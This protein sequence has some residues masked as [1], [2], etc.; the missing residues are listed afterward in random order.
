[1]K[2]IIVSVALV[3]IG[4]TTACKKEVIPTPPTNSSTDLKDF[5]SSKVNQL[6]QNFTV[7]AT[8]GATIIGSRGTKVTILPNGLKW[9]NGQTVSGNVNIELVEIFDRG[10]MVLANKPTMG[11]LPNGDLAPLV[12]GGEYYLRITQNGQELST[13]S[14]VFIE[15]PTFNLDAGMQLFDGIIDGND[16]LTWDLTTDTINFNQDSLGTT[17]AFFDDSW[18]WTNVDR[19][20]DDPRPKTTIKVK[21]PSG[22]DNSNANVYITYDGEPT[23][24]ASLDV[25]TTDGYFSEHYGLIP[26]GLEIHVIAI[27]IVDGQLNY[28]ILPQT[29]DANEIM[30]MPSFSPIS[31]TALVTLINDLP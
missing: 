15:V 30:I 25:F 17:Y 9:S 28:A 18:G 29:V 21:L 20:Y 14:G 6:K 26:I 1:M 2:K 4:L 13:T 22:F 27:T 31:E 11:I 8:L 7:N 10:T 23:A 16:N 12:S 19:F 5:H 24:L 3:V